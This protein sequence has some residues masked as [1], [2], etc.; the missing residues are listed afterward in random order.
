MFISVIYKD[1]VIFA[2]CD[3]IEGTHSV[4]VTEQDDAEIYIYHKLGKI[5]YAHMPSTIEFKFDFMGHDVYELHKYYNYLY[6]ENF[7]VKT[8]KHVP[9]LSVYLDAHPKHGQV[10][11]SPS[12][13]CGRLSR[14][15]LGGGRAIEAVKLRDEQKIR[16]SI[17]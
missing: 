1:T 10:I 9:S 11:W 8:P 4:P 3:V 12:Y 2:K 6:E 16:F 14:A 7:E 13:I 15:D 5:K 17:V